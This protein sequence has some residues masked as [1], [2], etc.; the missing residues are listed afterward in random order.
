VDT[1]DD[2][3]GCAGGEATSAPAQVIERYI[4]DIAIEALPEDN[5]RVIRN[6]AGQLELWM[7][8]PIAPGEDER[9]PVRQAIELLVAKGEDVERLKDAMAYRLLP[10]VK[11]V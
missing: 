7:D 11:G 4:L 1:K 2:E 5:A 6:A 3:A 10:P 9:R 8:V